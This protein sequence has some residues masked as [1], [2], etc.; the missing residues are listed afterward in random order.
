VA[1]ASLENAV[2]D[3]IVQEQAV[4]L[5]RLKMRRRIR[6]L[7]VSGVTAAAIAL[8]AFGSMWLARP[9]AAERTAAEVLAQGAEAVPDPST[10]QIVAKMRTIAHDNFAMIGDTYDFVPVKIWKQFGE[11]PKWRVEKP[12][13]VAVMDGDS[14]MML[15]RPNVAVKFPQPSQGAFDT[16]WLLALTNVQDM[17][18]HELRSAQARGWDLKLTHET[19]GAGVKKLLVTVEAKSGLPADDY[20]KNKFFDNADMRRVYRFDEKTRRLEGF[21]AYLHKSGGDVLI[22]S[23]ERIEYDRPFDAA[24]F[25]LKLPK[26]VVFYKE[27]ERLP[28]NKKYEKMTPEQAARAFFEPSN[29]WEASSFSAWVRRSNRKII[30]AGSFRTKSRGASRRRS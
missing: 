13:R 21:D 7:G 8:F 15:I 18:T 4:Q 24:V 20:L 26:D 5:R 23:I 27:P 14:T 22:L 12:G 19:T 29:T 3:R 10:V 2:M 16:G 1:P 6:M 30:P 25:T 17:V 28:D 11:K 9:A